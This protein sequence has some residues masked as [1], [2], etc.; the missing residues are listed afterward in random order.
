MQVVICA[1]AKNEHLYINEWLEHYF[2]LGFDKIFIFDNDD[3][4]SPYIKD[5]IKVEYLNKIKII[6][7]RGKSW[8]GMQH[9]FYTN[10]Y[11]AEKDN[12]DWCLY[13]DIDE[14]LTGIDN[15]KDFLSNKRFNSYSQIRIKW[16]LFGDD[17]QIERDMNKPIMECFTKV[18]TKSLTN[19]LQR[20]NTLQNQG[21]TIIRGHLKN[22]RFCS[23]HYAS[24]TNRVILSSC[25]PS[26]IRCWSGVAI[27]EDYSKETVFL[28]HYMT[29]SLSEFVNQKLSRTDAVFGDRKLKLNYYWRIND[30]TDEK[31]KY[32][33]DMGLEI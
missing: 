22:V 14:F 1:L 25:L 10:F 23:V 24:N 9:D 26:G 15:I 31:I 16:K 6:N 17:N 20:P 19:D 12:F 7:A 27:T 29:K 3:K 21:K 13:C 28:N 30:K 2:K 4:G 33:K 5:T 11:E 18:I 8:K 32:L